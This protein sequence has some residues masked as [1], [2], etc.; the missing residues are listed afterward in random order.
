MSNLR[1]EHTKLLIVDTVNEH[2]I[3]R[4]Y[5]Y[6]R[7][8]IHTYTHRVFIL[9]TYNIITDRCRNMY[10]ITTILTLATSIDCSYY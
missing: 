2:V 10:L 3:F 7:T 4:V 1:R 8:Y 5:R 6:I 9:Y